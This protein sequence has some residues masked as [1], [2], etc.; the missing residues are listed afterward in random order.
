MMQ[1]EDALARIGFD[2]DENEPCQVCVGSRPHSRSPP[3]RAR[4]NRLQFYNSVPRALQL[5]TDSHGQ[6]W[7]PAQRLAFWQQCDF[8]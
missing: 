1:T 7:T 6:N 5:S 3:L 8:C 4:G 2:K